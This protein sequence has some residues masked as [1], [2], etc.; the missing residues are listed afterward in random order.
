MELLNS[1]KYSNKKGDNRIKQFDSHNLFSKSNLAIILTL[2]CKNNL[3]T[4][5]IKII[6]VALENM[7]NSMTHTIYALNVN[8]NL[9]KLRKT[10]KYF[11]RKALTNWKNLNHKI[12]NTM[13]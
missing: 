9:K 4:Q 11:M 13:M 6:L 8:K 2:L 1:I 12:I 5:K 7:T 3:L 10:T